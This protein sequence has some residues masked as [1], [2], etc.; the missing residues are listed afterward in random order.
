VQ[1]FKIALG[2]QKMIMRI[3]LD[4]FKR[5]QQWKSCK[6][7]LINYAVLKKNN[8]YSSIINGFIKK[9]ESL[10]KPDIKKWKADLVEK[11]AMRLKIANY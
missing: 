11:L 3:D 5:D 2:N 7:Q 9:I 4:K 8:E 10:N 6:E 1:L